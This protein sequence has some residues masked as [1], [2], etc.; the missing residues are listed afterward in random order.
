MVLVKAP[1]AAFGQT[2]CWSTVHNWASAIETKCHIQEDT[3]EGSGEA[4]EGSQGAAQP[5]P[6]IA[7]VGSAA[8]EEKATKKRK[9]RKYSKGPAMQAVGEGLLAA[10]APLQVQH[11]SADSTILNAPTCEC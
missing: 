1:P 11:Q 10:A 7:E 8:E 5:N 9:K 4:A 6:S 3:I 2:D